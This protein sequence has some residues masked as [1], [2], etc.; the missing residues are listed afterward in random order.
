VE[1]GMEKTS[2]TSYAHLT[3]PIDIILFISACCGVESISVETY[4][5]KLRGLVGQACI[6]SAR[7]RKLEKMLLHEEGA[8]IIGDLPEHL[9][10]GSNGAISTSPAQQAQVIDF[11]ERQAGFMHD[12]WRAISGQKQGVNGAVMQNFTAFI[13]IASAL[14]FSMSQASSRSEELESKIRSSLLEDL[15]R[16]LGSNECSQKQKDGMYFALHGFLPKASAVV[17]SPNT[18]SDSFGTLS[19][20]V[21]GAIFQTLVDKENATASFEDSN[22]RDAMDIDDGFGFPDHDREEEKKR[23]CL[24]REEVETVHSEDTFRTCSRALLSLLTLA[25]NN[26]EPTDLC[27]QFAVHLMQTSKHHLLT[28]RPVIVD[29]LE[30]ACHQ[31]VDEDAVNL[32]EYLAVELL[33]GYDLERCEISVALC[34]DAIAALAPRWVSTENT[35]VADTCQM[36]FNHAIKTGVD[37]QVTSYSIRNQIATLL[38]CILEAK[39]NYRKEHEQSPLSLYDRLLRDGDVR[40]IFFVTQRLRVLFKVMGESVHA[41]ICEEIEAALPSDQ[42]W[43]EGLAMRIHTLAF[44]A[45]VSPSN[46]SRIVYRIFETGQIPGVENHAAR[47]LLTVAKSFGLVSQRELFGFFGAKLIYTWTEHYDFKDFPFAVWGYS[48]L[49]AMCYDVP[50]ELIAQLMAGNNEEGASWVASTLDVKLNDL[51]V[52]AFP[53]VI[54]YGYAWAVGIPPKQ[55]REP[56]KSLAARVQKHIGSDLFSELFSK[57]FPRIVSNIYLLMHEDGTA[58]KL[59]SKDAHLQDALQTFRD[60]VR[61]GYSSRKLKEALNP[62]FKV[63][64]ILN[65]LHHVSSALKVEDDSL[66]TPAMVTF[67]ARQLFNTLHPALGPMH[68]CG[69]IRNI[70]FLIC[71]AR[72]RVHEGYPLQMLIHGLKH[73]VVEPVCAED[74]IGIVRYLLVNGSDYLS[75]H[76]SFVIG[77]FLSILASLRGY[78]QA[79]ENAAQQDTQTL[80]TMSTVRSFHSWLAEHLA[81]MHFATLKPEQN[82]AFQAIVAS[83]IELK[84]Y[85]NASQGTKESEL[86]RQLLD[87]DRDPDKLLDDVSRVLAFSMLCSNFSRPASFRDD[88]FGTDDESFERSRSLLRICRRSDVNDGFLLWSA[89]VLGRAYASTGQLHLDWMQEMEFDYPKDVVPTNTAIDL[90]PRVGILRRLK[91]LLFSNDKTVVGLVETTLARVIYS[92]TF[93]QENAL[94]VVLAND[95]YAALQWTETPQNGQNAIQSIADLGNPGSLAVTVWIKNL[96]VSMCTNMADVPMIKALEEILRR[97][98]GLSDELFPY[99]THVFLTQDLQISKGLRE[100]LSAVFQMCFENCSANTVPHNTILIKTILYLRSQPMQREST[101]ARRDTWLDINYLDASQAACTCRMFKAALL[102]AEIHNYASD[103]EIPSV[104]LLEIFKNIDDPDSFYGVTQTFSLDTVMESFEYEGDGWKSLSLRGANLESDIRFGVSSEEESL[105]VI[106]ALN[107]LG[108]NGLSHSFLQGGSFAASASGKTV[109]NTY[110]SAWK[111]EQ[112]DLPCPTTYDTRSAS[113]YRALQS[114]N[115]TM[116]SRSISSH[117]DPPFLDV[118]K[119]MVSGTQTGHTLCEGMRTLAMLTEMEEVLVSNN[120]PQLDEAWE[121]LQCRNI[122]METGK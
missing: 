72:E 101:K 56:P 69:V 92:E 76:P 32:Y 68:T 67:V 47:A 5:Q 62:H 58:E 104:L 17:S 8:A 33:R 71:L 82:E 120:P 38:E 84:D 93:V 57:H 100:Q 107:A 102:F 1:E 41:K 25:T 36:V 55:G 19:K 80:S 49:K 103:E 87:D 37:K 96:T 78:L 7:Y 23:E 111:L 39:P 108:M 9:D 3:S 109:D 88:I 52:L 113:I 90:V 115:N 51:L 46:I 29:Y 122:W 81:A 86:L 98:D 105:G 121:R 59:L 117:V 27:G 2:A 16:F 91:A 11:L 116:D 112:W 77:A 14:C 24:F 119:R 61:Q 89:R 64:F 60:I 18:I 15:I 44:I 75:K 35:E 10:I 28:M 74:A 97:V 34:I 40:V 21:F 79:T 95:E 70:R 110:R 99:I 26:P 48:S 13:L 85:G 6:R 53:K 73:F 50:E 31:F 30:A 66:W 83:A 22:K 4:P 12:K 114:V 43:T 65:A 63:K 106:N 20:Q 42:N 94:N 45:V 118:M 54:A